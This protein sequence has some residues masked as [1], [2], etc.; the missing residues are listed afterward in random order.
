M[1]SISDSCFVSFHF[2]SSSFHIFVHIL[3]LQREKFAKRIL[4]KLKKKKT[5]REIVGCIVF[6]SIKVS[7]L[8]WITNT[9]IIFDSMFVIATKAVDIFYCNQ[10]S[11]KDSMQRVSSPFL[12]EKSLL[13]DVRWLIRL[14]YRFHIWSCSK[15]I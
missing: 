4:I 12:Y 6:M 3:Y 7:H 13:I 9:E 15:K 8:T 1:K 14:Q 10:R 5:K 11:W 2:S